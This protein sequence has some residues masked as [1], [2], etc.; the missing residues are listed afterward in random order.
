MKKLPEFN[1]GDGSH[2]PK[3]SRRSIWKAAVE[4]CKNISQLAL[5]VCLQ[6]SMFF[7]NDCVSICSP[8]I[9]LNLG[10]VRY[11]DMNIRWSELVRPEQTVQDVKAG[12][13]TE[14]SVFRNAGIRDKKII[15]KKVR[16]GVA[17]GNQKH[18]PSRVMKNVIEV[19]KT[20][21]GNEKFWFAEARVPLYLI[22]E[23]E[24]SLRRVHVPFIK[25]LSERLSKLQ[26]KQLK[27]SQANIFS[28][29][30][31][32]RDNTEKCSCA[33]CHLDVLLRYFL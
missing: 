31:S 6:S 2:I 24:E 27:A 12:P 25:K 10:Q 1:Y 16:Y 23:Y 20:E 15:D 30:A 13:E 5:Q 33:S 32:R 8:E 7:S 28:Y 19:E 29:L 11:L 14:A 9:Q 17:F 4:N 26:R 22:K 21:D 18:L 3:R